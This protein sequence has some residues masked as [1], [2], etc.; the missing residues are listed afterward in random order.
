MIFSGVRVKDINTVLH[1]TPQVMKFTAKNRHDHIIGIQLS[2]SAKHFF[3]DHQFTL[4]ESCIYF[5][6]QKE[7]YSVEVVEKGICFSV[8]FTT[9]EPIE[10]KRF[11]IKMNDYHTITRILNNIEQQFTNAGG[12]TTGCLSKLYELFGS[13][14]DAY[15]KKYTPQNVK[16]IKAKE[17]LNLHFKEDQ[18]IAKA[19]KE[20]GVTQRRFNDIFKQ[21][22]HITPN[23]YIIDYKMDLAKKL[24][25]VNELS[26]GDISKLCGF[27][28]IYYFC[29]T[30][31]KITGQTASDYRK[32]L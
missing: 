17:Y 7:D 18:C 29:K 28:D 23:Q 16:L 31:K 21:N 1:Y 26:V 2:G 20:Y 25:R 11:C 19:A 27:E 3:D 6:N 15:L 24:L 32:R 10:I 22:F 14:E 9:Y 5:F 12:C 8:H 13:F 4:D 30:F